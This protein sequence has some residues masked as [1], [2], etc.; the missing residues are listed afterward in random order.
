MNHGSLKK[1]V[2]LGILWLAFTPA[3]AQENGKQATLWYAGIQGGMPFGISQFSSFSAGKAH[4][5]YA[6]GLHG[7]YRFNSLFLWRRKPL[8]AACGK[9]RGIVAWI[10]GLGR[11]AT[12]TKPPWQA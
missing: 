12:A 4:A 10:I 6:I 3:F 7:G 8:G 5:G 9:G 2:S 11:T 1:I